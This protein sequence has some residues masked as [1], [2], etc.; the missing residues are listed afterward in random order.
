MEDVFKI[1][2]DKTRAQDL[3]SMAK[4][5]LK[6]IIPV[7]PKDKSYKIIEEYYEIFVQL[8]TSLMYSDGY[9]TLSHVSLIEYL[10]GNYQSRRSNK[11]VDK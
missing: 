2:K 7:I 6:D 5:R 8:I 3:Y 1:S 4:E 9:K 11:R 10:S